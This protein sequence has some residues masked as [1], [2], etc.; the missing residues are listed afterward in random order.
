M[1]TVNL[2]I[3]D[4]PGI[5]VATLPPVGHLTDDG[6]LAIA[7]ATIIVWAITFVP[8][9]IV[10]ILNDHEEDVAFVGIM[11]V[12]ISLLLAAFAGFTT[13]DNI[14]TDYDVR[15]AAMNNE[16]QRIPAKTLEGHFTRHTG[17]YALTLDE[18][19]A[20]AEVVDLAGKTCRHSLDID[21]IADNGTATM[22][23]TPDAQACDPLFRHGPLVALDISDTTEDPQSPEPGA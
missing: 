8:A 11:G 7:T 6:W 4:D 2:P 20:T 19:F 9:V 12:T 1:F 10:T 5:D 13:R 16:F 18:D 15:R 23:L 21:P 22:T 3:I 17:G 14:V